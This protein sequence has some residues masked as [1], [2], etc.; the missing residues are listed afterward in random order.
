MPRAM[1]RSR[2]EPGRNRRRWRARH[3]ASRSWARR[4]VMIVLIAGGLVAAAYYLYPR[5]ELALFDRVDRR[6]LC[7]HSRH[8][9]GAPD[10]R[11]RARSPRGQQRLRQE[12]GPAH[13]AGRRDGAGPGPPGGG[14]RR[15]GAGRPATRPSPRRRRPSR[16]ARANRFKLAVDDRRREQPDRRPA[17]RR[18]PGWK[19]AAGR[20]A[21]GE[22]RGRPLRRAG[23][24]QCGHEGA[25]RRPPDRLRAGPG[26]RLARRSSRSTA[27]ARPW[28]VAEEP[29]PG[30]ELD[31][32]PQGWE[33]QHPNVLAALG[34]F[35]VNLAELGVEVPS[36]YETP[37]EFLTEIRRRPPDGDIDK[38][39]ARPSRRPRTS[40][41]PRAQVEQAEAQ[42]A[43]ARLE[44]SY[45]TDLRRH[46][47]RRLQPERQPRRPGDAGPAAAG[48]PL[49]RRGLGRLQ[50]QGDPARADPDRPSGRAP[51]QRLPRQGLPGPGDRIQPGHRRGHGACCRPRT[52]RGTSSRSSSGC[53]CGST[54][55]AA[56]R[57]TRR[58][59]PACRSSRGSTSTRS[60]KA[61]TP[62]SG[63]GARSPPNRTRPSR[64]VRAA[65]CKRMPDHRI[66][67]AVLTHERRTSAT[68]QA[69]AMQPRGV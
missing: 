67:S 69:W 47:R 20:R 16:T 48:R 41:P 64:T 31:D 63:S 36:Y 4:L 10:H 46:R 49:A 23:P 3:R 38:L 28:P 17:R 21:A 68:L 65:I 8:A 24:P 2:T 51:G 61:R 60:P 35:A 18:S 43:E 27:S 50:L 57:P 52:P 66:G 13:R 29:E 45:C 56:T 55:S 33:Q 25:G 14:G 39:I 53:R 30:K 62:A 58:C 12:G 15:G 22:G 6:R 26:A 1:R 44:L 42:L 19:E 5:V 11:E 9:G 7:Q 32:V 34:Q 54:S 40:R 37:D 59:S